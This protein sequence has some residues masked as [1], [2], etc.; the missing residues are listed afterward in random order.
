ME[1]KSDI[2]HSKRNIFPVVDGDR[3]LLGILYSEKLFS[4][5]L[6]EEEGAGR[7]FALLAQKPTDIIKE[8]EDMERVMQKMNKEDVWILPVVDSQDRYLG[9]ISKAAVF[10][11]Y[12][13]LLMR[14]GT[15][16]E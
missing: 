5:L 11:K 12:R 6:G 10:N 15:Y 1:R 7:S 3:K 9:F 8:D 2:I 4:I 14:Q 13:A 16:L